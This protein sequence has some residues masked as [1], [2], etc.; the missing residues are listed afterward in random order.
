[1]I[2]A[3]KEC[4]ICHK[5]ITRIQS[6]FE[7][8][9]KLHL[10]YGCGHLDI[11]PLATLKE[12]VKREETQEEFIL[13]S[14]RANKALME[15]LEEKRKEDKNHQQYLQ[16]ELYENLDRWVTDGGPIKKTDVDIEHE[17]R[18]NELSLANSCWWAL[19]PCKPFYCEECKCFH[20]KEHGWRY[21]RE[22]TLFSEEAN[23]VNLFGDAMCLGKTIQICL[24]LRRNKQTLLPAL[25]LVR[26]ATLFQW[27]GELKKWFSNDFNSVMPILDRINIMPGFQVYVMSQDLLSRKGIKQLIKRLKIKTVIIDEVQFYKDHTSKRST[28]VSELIDEELIQY[29]IFASGTYIKNRMTEAYFVLNQLDSNH[30]YEPRDLRGWCT[31]NDKGQ[32]IK[33]DPN[34]ELE[35]KILTSKYIIRREREDVIKRLPAIQRDY[36]LIEVEDQA[37]KDS[38]NHEI[39]LFQSFLNNETNITSNQILGWLA[40]LRAQTGMA[41]VTHAVEW[42]DE[43]LDSC[44]DNIIIGC[45]HDDVRETLYSSFRAKGYNP[46]S[47]SGKDNIYEKER[48][49][50]AFNSKRNRILIMNM[51]AGGTGLSLHGCTNELVLERAW[52]SADEEQFELRMRDLVLKKLGL[53]ITYLIVKG[54][55][56]EFFHDMVWN[57]RNIL[58]AA[59]IGNPDE[60]INTIG[61][62]KEFAEFVAGR[63]I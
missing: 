56:D 55:I 10:V 62:L 53:M 34:R 59:G 17:R 8:M 16:R 42:T 51:V 29:K 12:E 18:E 15:E 30:F 14:V 1:M 24:T 33:L 28:S 50:Q 11:Q 61:F 43:F 5:Q 60:D 27:A 37:I 22:G 7:S 23:F 35:F 47:L 25:A 19:T 13:R 41:K 44:G 63:T 6:Q 36:Q 40:R 4:P 48:I 45:H 38:Y 26:G 46:L 2:V 58:A 9:G 21:Q 49:K 32:V 54:T 57:K 31:T 52:N 20:T 39:G 3:N